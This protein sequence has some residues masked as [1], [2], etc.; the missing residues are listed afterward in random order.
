MHKA[1][2]VC[3][4]DGC[5]LP[6]DCTGYTIHTPIGS[7]RDRPNRVHIR[8][9]LG[10][11]VWGGREGSSCHDAFHDKPFT[12]GVTCILLT[13]YLHVRGGWRGGEIGYE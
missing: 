2:L 3:V 9:G 8:K 13:I 7:P 6:D 11:Y 4:P 1:V 10:F 12:T 5:A